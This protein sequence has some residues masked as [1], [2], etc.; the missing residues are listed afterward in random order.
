MSHLLCGRYDEACRAAYKAVQANPAH[1]ITHVQLAAALAKLGRL[2][3]ARAA[4]ARV[5]ELHP[6]F[7]SLAGVTLATLA[8]PITLGIDLGLAAGNLVG[9]LGAVLLMIRAGFAH[10]PELRAGRRY[11]ASRFCAV[12]ASR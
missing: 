11:W 8:E 2:E 6:T 7:R 4:A 12:S 10:L 1:S 9:V 5:L 3:E